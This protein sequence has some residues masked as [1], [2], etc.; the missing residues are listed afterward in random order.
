MGV[1]PRGHYRT[2]PEEPTEA[3]AMLEANINEGPM[4]NRGG[5]KSIGIVHHDDI[6]CID[7]LFQSVSEVVDVSVSHEEGSGPYDVVG[8]K[9][10][11]PQEWPYSVQLKPIINVRIGSG[12]QVD[13]KLS[14]S[15]SDYLYVFGSSRWWGWRW[16][17]RRKS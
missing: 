15:P 12:V 8:G 10:P 6:A 5:K 3:L 13:E 17:S 16:K 4:A 2:S 1:T 7:E 14:D 11:K 9:G